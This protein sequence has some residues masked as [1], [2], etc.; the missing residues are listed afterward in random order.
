MTETDTNLIEGLRQ[1]SPKA[2]QQMLDRYGRDVFA[3]VIRLVS[4]RMLKRYIRMS[5][6]RSLNISTGMTL[7]SHHSRPG[8]R[9]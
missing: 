1:Q 6:S 4:Q 3:Q 9:A 5:L 8:C 7:R 2:Q